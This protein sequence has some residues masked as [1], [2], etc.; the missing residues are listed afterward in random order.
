[1][2]GS[3]VGYVNGEY[4]ELFEAKVDALDRG[5]IFGDGIYEVIA[6]EN[7]SLFQLEEH[8]ERY[9]QGAKEMLFENYPSPAAIKNICLRL[10]E[11]NRIKKGIIYFQVTRGT[12]PRTHA[13]PKETSPN[14]FMF[15]DKIDDPDEEKRTKGVKAI[16]VPDER[17]DRCHVKSINLLPN[18]FY[19]EKAKRSGAFEAI[20]VCQY[21][22]SEGTST[23]VFGVKD[24][25]IFTAPVGKK[26]LSGIT[27]NTV[28]Q[29]AREN[30]LKVEEKFLSE[31]KLLDSDE[32]FITSTT[33]KLLPVKQI[34]NVKFP[35]SRYEVTF[36][37]QKKLSD[38]IQRK[39][40]S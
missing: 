40:R 34:N 22:V 35:V 26:V 1:M 5:Y 3:L 18:C 24:N 11:K 30:G 16:L 6:I 21:G 25:I 27:R 23:N 8:L 19:K 4:V 36:L 12:S 29:L 7:G 33:I 38:F 10:Q 20:Q 9:E 15:A 32:I 2:S 17:W 28:L 14:I 13:F 31:E 39:T 37:L